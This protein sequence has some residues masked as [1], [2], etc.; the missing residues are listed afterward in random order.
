MKRASA[1]GRHSQR[2]DNYVSG[3]Q[4]RKEWCR[5]KH[6]GQK[7]LQLGERYKFKALRKPPW[8]NKVPAQF[9]LSEAC[10]PHPVRVPSMAALRR[11]GVGRPAQQRHKFKNLNLL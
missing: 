7:C 3:L 8:E 10:C 1:A 6:T 11:E 4:D 9:L 2:S 5:G